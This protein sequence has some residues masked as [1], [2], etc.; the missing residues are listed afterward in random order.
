M[1]A[2][3]PIPWALTGQFIGHGGDLHFDF[4]GEAFTATE[5]STYGPG[6]MS[7]AVGGPICPLKGLSLEEGL[8]LLKAQGITTLPMDAICGAMAEIFALPTACM[9]L[10]IL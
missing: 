3:T 5:V 4:E 2:V 9:E 6:F 7:E 8:P 1:S 10:Q